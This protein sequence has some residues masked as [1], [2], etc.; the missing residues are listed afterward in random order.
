MINKDIPI[1]LGIAI[2]GNETVG[3][4]T[5]KQVTIAVQITISSALGDIIVNENEN[6]ILTIDAASIKTTTF[7]SGAAD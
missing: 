3:Q 5:I 1:A 6:V 7:V 4:S 2:G